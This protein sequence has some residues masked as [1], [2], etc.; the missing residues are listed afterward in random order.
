MAFHFDTLNCFQGRRRC[1]KCSRQGEHLAAVVHLSG[2][3]ELLL[4][5]VGHE[6][7]RHKLKQVQTNIKYL[8]VT[9]D[10][11]IMARINKFGLTNL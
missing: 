4:P 3:C 6:L 5:S 11:I 10:A 7:R 9:D 1:R 2:P 8:A